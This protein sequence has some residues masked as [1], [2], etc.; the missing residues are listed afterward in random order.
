LVRH[1]GA[2]TC[3]GCHGTNG[4]NAPRRC[5]ICHN[6][7]DLAASPRQDG[8]HRHDF[9][10]ARVRALRDR[11][12]LTCHVKP[13]MDGR[14]ELDVD[15]TAIR[16][17]FGDF[18]PYTGTTDFCLRCH[19]RGPHPPGVR[20]RPRPGLGL[21]DPLVAI[22]DNYTLI[23]RHGWVDGGG[24]AYHGLRGRF[25][26]ATEVACTTCHVMHG[27]RN[28]KLILDDTRKGSNRMQRALP[29]PFRA[30]VRGGNY[31]EFCVLCHRMED[32]SIEEGAFDAG[33]GLS[34]VHDVTSDCSEC[35]THGE[36]VLG[37][38]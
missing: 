35:H 20:L 13:D 27:T 37:G 21:N 1:K 31:A 19:N 10:V 2:A 24:G 7:T 9:S 38:L 23:D 12:C 30:R 34:G 11:D 6:P 32:P 25:R 3:T 4:T 33:N 8:A 28:P 17:A 18:S 16:D 15:L 36:P 26:Y 14:F 5:A 29:R 22:E